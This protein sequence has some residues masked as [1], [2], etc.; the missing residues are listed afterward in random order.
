MEEAVT[1]RQSSSDNVSF[2]DVLQATRRWLMALTCAVGTARYFDAWLAAV[3][4]QAAL[5]RAER[6]AWRMSDGRALCASR[7]IRSVR[8]IA[9]PMLA[10][11][12]APGRGDIRRIRRPGVYRD[13]WTWEQAEQRW[14]Q[15]VLQPRFHNISLTMFD[16]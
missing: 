11:A 10:L 5:E 16:R 8:A 7:Q 4:L 3:Q 13:C 14:R 9:A 6:Q 15:D 2:D 1:G 12:P